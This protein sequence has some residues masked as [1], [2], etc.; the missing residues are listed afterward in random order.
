[1]KSANLSETRAGCT[2]CKSINDKKKMTINHVS[3]PMFISR[4]A[5]TMMQQFGSNGT[6]GHM[7]PRTNKEVI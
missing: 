5:L 7:K 3:Y 2:N 6:N 1:M 4:Y